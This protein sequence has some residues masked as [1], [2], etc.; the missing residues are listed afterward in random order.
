MKFRTFAILL[1]VFASLSLVAC[2]S[3]SETAS[4]TVQ[5]STQVAEKATP[6]LGMSSDPM[7]M[8]TPTAGMS[9]MGG[10]GTPQI[11][12]A[13]NDVTFIDMMVPHHQLAV[14]MAKI[15]QEKA[16]HGEL[17]GLAND[18]IRAQEDEIRRMGMWRGDL[19]GSATPA[20]NP[21][22]EVHMA[23]MDVDLE[24]LKASNTFDRDFILAMIPHHQSAIDMSRASLPNL[25]YAPLHDLANDIITTQQIEIDRMN[26][27]LKEWK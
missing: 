27:W 12:P 6:T 26:G 16:T 18:I 3:G 20:A 1:T 2:D 10:V 22:G 19:A 25:K 5:P 14:D 4:P 7:Q 17:K 13:P 23:G 8:A 9:H 11:V 24:Q 21:M 15:A